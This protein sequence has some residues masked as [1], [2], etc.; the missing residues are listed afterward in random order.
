M[1]RKLCDDTRNQELV[2]GVLDPE[3]ISA[4]EAHLGQCPDCALSVRQYRAL[5]RDLAELPFPPVPEGL[6][7]AV[8]AD[9]RRLPEGGKRHSILGFF[10]RRPVLA[11]ALGATMVAVIAVLREPML[12]LF[13]RMTGGIVAGSA[14]QLVEGIREV[15]KSLSTLGVVIHPIVGVLLKLESVVRALGGALRAVPAQAS[16]TSILLS[17]ATAILLGRLLGQVRRENLGHAKF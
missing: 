11:L 4:L 12:L 6:A 8:L 10:V 3:E 16:A 13:G 9:L 2:L 7:A 1:E 14:A 15:L 17:L 5:F